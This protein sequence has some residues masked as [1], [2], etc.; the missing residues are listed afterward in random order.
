[1]KNLEAIFLDRDGVLNKDSD[2][3]VRSVEDV[4]VYPFVSKV[5]KKLT[6]SG[7]KVF[8]TSNQSAISRGYFTEETNSKI[9][10]KVISDS[11]KAGGKITDYYYCPH[12]P[13]DNCNCRKP[14]P[15]MFLQAAKEYKFNIKNSVYVGDSVC[16]YEAAKNL[17]IPFFLVETGYGI[18]TAETI[19]REKNIEVKTWKNL[20]VVA[21]D[22]L[23]RR[24]TK[25][26]SLNNGK[27]VDE[28]K[29]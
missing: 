13:T 1:M 17:G 27:T 16:D 11:E 24:G 26:Q 25:T 20:K 7:L 10:K 9:F 14:R 2:D 28:K 29:I 21:E 8:I 15:G 3:Y 23:H 18:E 4:N 6:D 22:I 5:L 12:L 19:K